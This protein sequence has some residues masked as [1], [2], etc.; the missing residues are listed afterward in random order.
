MTN[1]TQA[2]GQLVLEVKDLRTHFQTRWGTVKAV[3]GVSFDLHRGETLGIVGESGSGKTTLGRSLLHL[4]EPTA[5][6]ILFDGENLATLSAKMLRTL[7]R[8]M[9]IIF[10]DPY[11][12]LNPRMQIKQIIS[13]P[14]RLHGMVSKHQSD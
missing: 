14:L 2:P 4:V 7:R 13:E 8:R 6:K 12:S 10:Q 11:A 5:G 1:G 3:D 9:Q